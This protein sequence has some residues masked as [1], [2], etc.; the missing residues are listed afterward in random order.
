MIHYF[1]LSVIFKK[2]N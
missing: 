2:C 1:T